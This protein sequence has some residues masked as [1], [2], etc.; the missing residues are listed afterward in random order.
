MRRDVTFTSQG[1]DCAGWLYVPDALADGQQAPAVV[2]ANAF[3]ATKEIYLSNHAE[4]LM[5]AGLVV[6]AFDYRTFGDSG[7]EPRC[8]MFPHEQLDDVRNAISWLGT[9]PEV[10]A[11]KIGAWGVSVGGGHVMFLSA[12]DKRIKATVALI[13]AINQWENIL[14]VMP[15]DALF[16]FLAMIAADRQARYTTGQVNYMQLVAPPGEMGIMGNEAYEFYTEAQRTVAPNWE[17]RI[18]MESLEKF[19]EYD[20]TGPIHLVSPTPLL[21]IVAEHDQIIPAALAQAAFER[22]E[23]PKKLM[24]LD[25]QHTDVYKVE[26]WVSQSADAAANWF[27]THLAGA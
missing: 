15:K 20:P 11:S 16:G 13:P 23:E 2:M 5:A 18:T 27:T 26:P 22:A 25:C 6:L 8:Q 1:V 12:F 3:S 19:T 14:S 4:R 7:G 24:M 17:N 10:D 9:Q 21:M